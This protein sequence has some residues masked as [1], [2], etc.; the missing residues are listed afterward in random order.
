MATSAICA[1][2]RQTLVENLAQVRSFT[3][4][5]FSV[6]DGS[7]HFMLIH[8]GLC[9]PADLFFSLDCSL[10]DDKFSLVFTV[11]SF[12]NNFLTLPNGFIYDHFGTMA[13]RFL[14]M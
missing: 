6:L 14:A 2:M 10:Q 7:I 11:A 1:S 5:A 8:F 13:T 12:M 9:L 3:E 4:V